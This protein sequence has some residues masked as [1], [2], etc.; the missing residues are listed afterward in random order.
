MPPRGKRQYTEIWAEEDGQFS[1][2][3]NHSD[4]DKLPS[5]Q[6]RGN[7]EQMTD[8]IAETDQISNGPMLNRL[9]ALMRSEGRPSLS[10]DESKPNGTSTATNGD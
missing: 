5:N 2:D 1:L 8:D 3:N 10:S 4:K 9:L 6:P 7:L